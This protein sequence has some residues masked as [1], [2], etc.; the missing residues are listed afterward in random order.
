MNG[1]MEIKSKTTTGFGFD[2]RIRFDGFLYMYID[3]GH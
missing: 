2:F 3:R 1:W